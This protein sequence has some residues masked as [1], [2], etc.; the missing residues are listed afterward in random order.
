MMSKIQRI[1]PPL[2][3]AIRFTAIHGLPFKVG[4][5]TDGRNEWP[6]LAAFEPVNDTASKV[7][8]YLQ[9]FGYSRCFPSR[10]YD[11][12]FECLY[13]PAALPSGHPVYEQS[14]LGARDSSP[15]YEDPPGGPAYIADHHVRFAEHVTI[16]AG[17]P[18][19]WLRWP[20]KGWRAANE[21]AA[22]VVRFMAAHG[23]EHPHP[24]LKHVISPWCELRG[25]FLP[26]LRQTEAKP[27]HKPP[28][29]V[30]SHGVL[31]EDGAIA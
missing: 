26:H 29:I 23:G 3:R 20:L 2:Y 5:E 8:D 21:S 11:H 25:L 4:E 24:D 15:D 30:T 13:L 16:D 9:R 7:A 1:E 14:G 18:F 17:R 28:P 6:N 27:A 31:T 10:P 22:Q 12:F 19:A